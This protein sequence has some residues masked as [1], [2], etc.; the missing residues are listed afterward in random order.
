[1]LTR[2]K[3]MTIRCLP[4]DDEPTMRPVGKQVNVVVT[5]LY[6]PDRF[7]GDAFASIFVPSIATT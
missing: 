1:M 4:A 6:F 7:D 2:R 5:G 3:V